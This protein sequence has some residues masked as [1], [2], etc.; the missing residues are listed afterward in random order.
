[1]A[2]Q[3]IGIARAVPAL[4]ARAHERREVPQAGD[5]GEDLRA[6]DRVRAHDDALAAVQRPREVEDPSRHG[7]LADVV[8][9]RHELELEHHVGREPQ[10]LADLPAVHGE[11][12]GVVRRAGVVVAQRVDELG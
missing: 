6:A 7:E 10:L 1:M 8:Q 9:D 11:A 3:P 12:V 2:R 5:L 4:V